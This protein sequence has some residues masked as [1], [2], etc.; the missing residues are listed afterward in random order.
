M[1]KSQIRCSKHAQ[2]RA[3]ERFN[4]KYKTLN[5]MSSKAFIEGIT[6]E[7]TKGE[8][9][10][11]LEYKWSEYEQA[12]NIRIHGEVIYMFQGHYLITLYRLSND[13]IKHLRYLKK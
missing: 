13:L 11:H 6:M 10:R 4:W 12:N 7:E 2:E 9:R 8:L 5:R 3:K 1:I